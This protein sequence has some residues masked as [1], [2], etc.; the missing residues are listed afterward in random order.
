[1]DEETIVP[2]LTG[3]AK[4]DA[5]TD[6]AYAIIDQRDLARET[7]TLRLRGLRLEREAAERAARAGETPKPKRKAKTAAPTREFEV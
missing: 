6:A 5:T 2:K 7:K 1:M 4:L 3:T